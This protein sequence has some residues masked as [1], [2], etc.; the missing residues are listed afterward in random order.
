M[1]MLVII[2]AE[3]ADIV[4]GAGEIAFAQRARGLGSIAEQFQPVFVGNRAKCGGASS[5]RTA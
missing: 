1:N 4:A 2:E 5:A 3:A